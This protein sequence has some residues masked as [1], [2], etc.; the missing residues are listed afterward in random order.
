MKVPKIAV[1]AASVCHACVISVLKLTFQNQKAGEILNKNEIALNA[2]RLIIGEKLFREVCDKM[3]GAR[4]YIKPYT[5]YQSLVERN[6]HI[7]EEWLSG[8][9]VKDLAVK[10]RL[11]VSRIH[12]II[13]K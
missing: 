10:Y 1:L 7:K 11:T 9:D 12:D 2:L 5:E 4:L 13:Y 6:N 3:A 8:A